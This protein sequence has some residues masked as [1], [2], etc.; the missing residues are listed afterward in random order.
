MLEVRVTGSAKLEEDVEADI[1]TFE[2]WFQSLDNDPLVRSEVA[3]LKT[4][5]YWKLRTPVASKG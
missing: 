3:I 1:K 4:Y 5:L 2:T